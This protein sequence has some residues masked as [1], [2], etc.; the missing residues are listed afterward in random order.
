[1]KPPLT[2]R[3]CSTSQGFTQTDLITCIAVTV[4][5]A[6]LGAS[7]LSSSKDNVSRMVCG[8]N[9]RQL[10]LAGGMYACDNQ[11]YLPFC[12]FDGGDGVDP[13]PGW[14]Y[15]LPVPKT[16]IGGGQDV[17]PDPFLTPWNTNHATSVGDLPDSA[18][19][20]GVYFHYVSS[21]EAYLCPTD[22]QSRDWVAEPRS[23]AG[24]GR[25]NKLCSYTMNGASFNY[26]SPPTTCK[27]SDVWN[28]DCYLLW[29]VDEN[30]EGPGAPGTFS[31]ND[32]ASIPSVPPNGDEGLGSL[33]GNNGGEVV[34]VGGNVNF[35]TLSAFNAQSQNPGSGP[36]GKSLAWWAPSASNGQ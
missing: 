5:L 13:A 11:D 19:Q 6:A 4:V 2:H 16:L 9:M 15:T 18:W 35:V 26:G 21:H 20:S 29:E 32:G 25:N 28:P 3:R 1:M 10:A 12:N 14:L 22:I 30:V 34:T 23:A 17:I 33:H 7:A 8:R 36:G 27:V 24:P 31:F